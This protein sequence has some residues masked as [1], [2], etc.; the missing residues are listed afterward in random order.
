ML[1]KR[2]GDRRARG[3]RGGHRGR[4]PGQAGHASPGS[5]LGSGLRERE[6]REDSEQLWEGQEEEAQHCYPKHPPS[7]GVKWRRS[8]IKL[9]PGPAILTCHHVAVER[10]TR[11]LGDHNS[12]GTIPP[13]AG[14][15][16]MLSDSLFSHSLWGPL[17]SVGVS[18]LVR[19]SRAQA[20]TVS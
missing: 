18:G 12:D 2:G 1:G 17:Q 7:R 6:T 3:G 11:E 10:G 15:R 13:Q 14:I 4:R 20:V 9:I 8:K 5:T 16:R 19:V